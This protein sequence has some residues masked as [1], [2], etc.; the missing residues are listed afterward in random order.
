[1][2]NIICK[3]LGGKCKCGSFK[4][5]GKPTAVFSH[6]LNSDGKGVI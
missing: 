1:M 6:F 5:P 2:K 3:R 4:L